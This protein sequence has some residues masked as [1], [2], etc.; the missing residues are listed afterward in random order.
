MRHI[1]YLSVHSP[2]TLLV[3]EGS[4]V[5]TTNLSMDGV[6]L[7]VQKVLRERV[8]GWFFSPFQLLRIFRLFV[9]VFGIFFFLFPST[10]AEIR[11]VFNL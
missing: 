11:C 10:N 9:L 6:E 7:A 2:F 4:S 3:G 8:P 5:Q 1:L